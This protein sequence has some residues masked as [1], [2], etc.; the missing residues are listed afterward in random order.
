M[1][2]LKE[3]QMLSWISGYV[4]FSVVVI[5]GYTCLLLIA[6][7][8]QW[9]SWVIGGVVGALGLLAS[10]PSVGF[11]CLVE[12]RSTVFLLSSLVHAT[13]IHVAL[14]CLHLWS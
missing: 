11:W 9:Y 5:G 1:V 13:C 14:Y 6:F 4:A 2:F 8:S 3:K 12:Y 7:S 10:L